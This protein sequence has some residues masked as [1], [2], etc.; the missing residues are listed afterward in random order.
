MEVGETKKLIYLIQTGEILFNFVGAE[1][2]GGM[3]PDCILL[4]VRKRQRPGQLYVLSR[5]ERIKII[6]SGN[7]MLLGR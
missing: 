1:V 5:M 4:N 6:P 7:V 2:A 3:G